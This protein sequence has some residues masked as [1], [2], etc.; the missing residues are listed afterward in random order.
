MSGHISIDFFG[1]LNK[2]YEL[3]SDFL[4]EIRRDGV[5]VHIISGLWLPDLAN[6]LEAAKYYQDTHYDYIHSILNYLSS[7]GEDTF[8]DEGTDSWYSTQEAWWSAKAEICRLNRIQVHLD[9]DIRFKESFLNVPTRFILINEPIRDHVD[10]VTHVM[11][12]DDIDLQ[13]AQKMV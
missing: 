4:E 7:V 8:Y 2:D 6:K 11:E 13:E 9:S 1:S 3:W 12:M 10:W 5:K